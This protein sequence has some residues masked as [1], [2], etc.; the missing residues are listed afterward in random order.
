[1]E[2]PG[3]QVQVLLAWERPIYFLSEATLYIQL[4]LTQAAGL[5]EHP[6]R[7]YMQERKSLAMEGIIA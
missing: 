7:R 6:E 1:M 4:W 5:L 2:L 3:I